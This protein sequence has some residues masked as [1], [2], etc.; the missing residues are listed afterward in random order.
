MSSAIGYGQ[1]IRKILSNIPEDDER[2]I[3]SL[4]DYFIRDHF[5]YT[6]F[7]DKPISLS[8]DFTIT[9][10]NH[11]LYGSRCG[12]CFWHEWKTWNKYKNNFTITN[13]ILFDEPSETFKDDRIVVLINKKAFINA[14]KK[15]S[16]VFDEILG[17][18]IQAENLLRAIESK[19]V[20]FQRAIKN[21]ELLWGILLGYGEHNA[22]LYAEREEFYKLKGLQGKNI[23]PISTSEMDKI[24]EKINSLNKRLQP[25]GEHYYLPLISDAV[26]FVADP[27]HSETQA[28]EKK[29][30]KLRGRI[31]A[32]YAKGDFLEIT[33]SK[34]TSKD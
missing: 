10:T 34:L 26:Y 17:Q 9:P 2:F 33:L 31:S 30:R 20:S 28:L 13:Y 16:D 11:I 12:G 3:Y 19:Q 18:H 32:I 29:Y 23:L 6:L 1:D 8:G 7:S 21:N 5:A 14:I 25:F 22:K 24:D 4:F 27:E 15:H